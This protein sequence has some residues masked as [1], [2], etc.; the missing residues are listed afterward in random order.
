MERCIF[1]SAPFLISAT[2]ILKP[3][4]LQNGASRPARAI[5]GGPGP[6]RSPRYVNESLHVDE[7]ALV[8]AEH[9]TLER[10]RLDDRKHADRQLLVA[11]QR[12]RG[13]VHD[14]QIAAD[15]LVEADRR[16]ACR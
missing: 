15:C 7:G 6:R 12:E 5:C 8:L 3:P 2:D 11:A 9:D 4:N 16:V 14:L 10:A 1:C 13:R